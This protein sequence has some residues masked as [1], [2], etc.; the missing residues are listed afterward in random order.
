MPLRLIGILIL[1]VLVAVVTGFNLG[2][3]CT[4]W[5]FRNFE[6]VP[7]FFALLAAFILGVIITLPFT[8]GKRRKPDKPPKEKF[9]RDEKKAAKA[10]RAGSAVPPKTNSPAVTSSAPAAKGAE[11]PSKPGGEGK[12]EQDK[13]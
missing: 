4:I 10:L 11:A 3:T 2:N 1:V 5:F 13:V 8:I 12:G 9:S 7:V 6:N